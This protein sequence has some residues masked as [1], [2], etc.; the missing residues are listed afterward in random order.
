MFPKFGLE[1]DWKATTA[2]IF[3]S[4]AYIFDD[5]AP[6]LVLEFV[7]AGVFEEGDGDQVVLGQRPHHQS[8]VGVLQGRLPLHR[9]RGHPTGPPR[10]HDA[11]FVGLP[12][13]EHFLQAP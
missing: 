11:E 9:G 1:L 4:C 5:E 3:F 6:I 13:K 10:P 12:L 7:G 8:L 2:K